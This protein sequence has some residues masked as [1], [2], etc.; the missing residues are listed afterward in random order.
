MSVTTGPRALHTDFT[1]AAELTV[2][3]PLELL[4]V[5]LEAEL[6]L[7]LLELPQPAIAAAARSRATNGTAIRRR[8]S[9]PL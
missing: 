2:E 7:L 3:D 9:V 5:E 1:Y 8:I 4:A 6:L